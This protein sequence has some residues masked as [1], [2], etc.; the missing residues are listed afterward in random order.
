MATALV[1]AAGKGERLGRNQPKALVELAGR[2]MLAW[3][4]RALSE[5]TTVDEVVIAAPPGIEARIET[6]AVE[7][8][9]TLGLSVVTGGESRSQSVA[10]ALAAADVDLVVVHDAA[11][12]LVSALLVDHCVEELERSGCDAVVAAARITDTIKQADDD[13]RVLGT[14]ERD[15]LWAAQTP[16]VFRAAALRDALTGA[17]DLERA[18]D[19]AQ[20]VERAGGVVRIVEAP[21]EN[22]KVT[23]VTDLQLAQLLLARLSGNAD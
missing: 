16:Q 2:P 11:R 5:S 19:D 9:P 10:N 17:P 3:S 6:L 4:I 20:L 12:P 23:A 14:L 7:A 15:R 21:R 8:A 1:V 18:S 13:G 22:I